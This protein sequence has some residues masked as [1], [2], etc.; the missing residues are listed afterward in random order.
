IRH[1]RLELVLKPHDVTIVGEITQ[2]WRGDDRSVRGPKSAAM[3]TRKPPS[4]FIQ[5]ARPLLHAARA[6]AQLYHDVVGDG[7][8]LG[9]MDLSCAGYQGRWAFREQGC[10]LG[11]RYERVVG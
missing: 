4:A 11:L 8:V 5:P 2:A 6:G 1:T 10:F 9:R 3:M 7:A